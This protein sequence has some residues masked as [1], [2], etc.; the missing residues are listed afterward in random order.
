MSIFNGHAIGGSVESPDL[1]EVRRAVKLI[2]DPEH[3]CQLLAIPSARRFV[4][5]GRDVDGLVSAAGVLADDLRV[6]ILLNPVATTLDHVAKTEDVIRRRWFSVGVDAVRPSPKDTNASD[7]EKAAALAVVS[8]MTDWLSGEEWGR[9]LVID[10]GNG[11]HVCYR[12]D[13]SNDDATR[14]RLRPVLEAIADKFTGERA[15]IE[16]DT[17]RA[18]VSVRLPGTWNRSKGANTP[19]RPHRMGKIVS[20]PDAFEPIPKGAIW[21][22]AP[23]DPAPKPRRRSIFDGQAANGADRY[24]EA[25]FAAELAR[26]ATAADGTRNRILN[27]AAFAVGQFIGA[28]RLVEDTVVAGLLAAA[29]GSGLPVKEAT[30]VI[31][32]GIR[33]GKKQPRAEKPAPEPSA[34]G[35]DTPTPTAAPE[36][37]T[38]SQLL[39][40]ELRD[41][42]WAIPGLLC[43]GLNILGGKPKLGKSW[44]ALNLCLTIAAG[45]MALGSTQTL[46]GDV[47]YL[48]LEDRLRRVKSRAIKIGA[49]HLAPEAGARLHIAVEWPR[50]DAGGLEHIE[51]WIEGARSPRLIVIDVWTMFRP[52]KKTGRNEYDQ[53]HEH[54]S[55][56]KKVADKHSVSM[57]VIHHCKKAAA[58]DVF[59]EISGTLGF[60]GAAD[61]LL[62]LS[63][64]RNED[65]A[66]LSVTGRDVDEQKLALRFN[67]DN[68]TWTNMGDAEEREGGEL[69]R[70]ICETMAAAAEPLYPS[71]VAG[72]C[73]KPPASIKTTM[74]RMAARGGLRKCGS[75]YAL[76]LPDEEG[77]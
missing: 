59:D 30:S 55:L 6:Q 70:I 41:P 46:A 72:R 53:D 52:R 48:S 21:G 9:P 57:L 4:L 67:R 2:A 18:L 61:G 15:Y 47:L 45:G 54:A 50:A 34:N 3:G 77:F 33:D 39:A 56:L 73:G 25:A 16:R 17:H 62:V 1:D 60:A 71:E 24:A 36:V 51:R 12:V 13:L 26:V 69:E 68:C 19:E 58:D 20:A 8:E 49:S 28:G 63:R 7:S 75:K 74:W 31:T 65:E 14:N 40:M 23:A 10:S 35:T 27:E 5:P 38:V 42:Q 22:I 66:I 43:E 11:Y 76:P 37:H 29:T 32:R 44:C 64:A